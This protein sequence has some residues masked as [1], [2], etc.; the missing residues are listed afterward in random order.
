[1]RRALLDGRQLV[2]QQVEESDPGLLPLAQALATL[3]QEQSVYTNLAR[4]IF[5]CSLACDLLPLQ[6]QETPAS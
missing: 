6:Q 2:Y 4:L 5:P 3:P 1:M